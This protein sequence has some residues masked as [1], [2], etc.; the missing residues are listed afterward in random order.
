MRPGSIPYRS[1]TISFLVSVPVSIAAD[2]N[3][4]TGLL[5]VLGPFGVVHLIQILISGRRAEALCFVVSA[6]QVFADRGIFRDAA[7]L[8]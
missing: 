2:L 7:R 5:H 8:G 4:S 1:L 3:G 6:V